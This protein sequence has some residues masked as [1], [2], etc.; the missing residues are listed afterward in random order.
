[1]L[2]AFGAGTSCTAAY[3]EP[4]PPEAARHAG[5]RVPEPDEIAM[6]HAWIDGGKAFV[7]AAGGLALGAK[8]ARGRE[9][10]ERAADAAHRA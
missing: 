2:F 8:M 10:R 5:V 3:L 7:W 4:L 9:K 6:F 1:M